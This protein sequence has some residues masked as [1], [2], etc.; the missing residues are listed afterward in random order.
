MIER[1]E[2]DK[3]EVYK[4]RCGDRGIHTAIRNA[5]KEKGISVK[6]LTIMRRRGG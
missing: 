4:K 5:S 3:I 6:T 1:I 2:K